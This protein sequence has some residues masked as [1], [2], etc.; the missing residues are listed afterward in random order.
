M[1]QPIRRSQ[2]I[3]TYGPGSILEGPDGPRIVLSLDRSRVFDGHRMTDFEIPDPD[4][5]QALLNG[6]GIIRL[7]SNAELGLPEARSVYE[8][9]RFPAWSLCIR[10][11]LLYKKTS[12]DEA[13]CPRCPRLS[14]RNEAWRQSQREAIRFVRACPDGHMDDVDWNRIVP[15][16]NNS[17]NPPYLVWEGG[18]G[19]LRHIDIVCPNCNGSIN[20][21]YAYSRGWH[22]SGRFPELGIDRLGC[23]QESKIIQRGASNL[24]VAE[25]QSALTIPPRSSRLHRLLEMSII[26]ALLATS[27]LRSKKEVMDSVSRLVNNGLILR[28]VLDE[29]QSHDEDE[30]LQAI[31]DVTERSSSI[32]PITLRLREFEALQNAA[33]VG[34]PPHQ[35]NS[36]GSPPY[37]EVVKSEVRI[38]ERP[39]GRCLRVTPVNRLRVVMVQT[40]YHRLDPLNPTVDRAFNDGQRLWYP[41]VELFGEGIFLDFVSP[42]T[43]GAKP[44]DTLLNGR[45][46]SRWFDAW[47]APNNFRQNVAAERRF[48]LHPSFVWWHTLAHRLMYGLSVDSGYSSASIRERVYVNIDEASGTA[49]GGLLLYT[50]QPGGDGT[51]GGLTALV[52]EFEKVL[53][54]AL[55]TIDSCSNDPLCGEEEFGA[56]KYNGAACYS[57]CLV[58]ETSCEYRNM[59]LDRNVLL[60]N[61]V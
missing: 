6:A 59:R 54:S 42:I 30:I 55:R 13:A 35:S 4:L 51:L 2:T 49:R 20:L 60:E 15:H 36:P 45:S 29:I 23:G 33:K 43:Q 31:S 9:D 26:S 41:G 25:L 11:G 50:A 17:C 5:S 47:I 46:A 40:G 24:H 44:Q 39:S 58:S 7:P 61:P 8:T 52:P 34:A 53:E 48:E 3:T 32:D 38:L 1:G 22:C 18:G 14:S 12:Q 57:C 37:F 16:N 27:R 10:H 19:A 21:G 28:S 56:G